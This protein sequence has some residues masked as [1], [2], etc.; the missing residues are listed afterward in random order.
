MS[1]E[2]PVFRWDA[3]G[4]SA[5]DA[6]WY[7]DGQLRTISGVNSKKFVRFDKYGIYGVNNVA[8]ID[9]ATWSPKKS[10]DIEGNASFYLTWDGL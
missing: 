4:I 5:Y 1:G 6:I 7:E 2:E 10:E 8:G 9:G 3:Y